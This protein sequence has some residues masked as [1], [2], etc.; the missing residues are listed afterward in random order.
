MFWL[1]AFAVSSVPTT[2]FSPLVTKM[3]PASSPAPVVVTL[4]LPAVGLPVPAPGVPK[5]TSTLTL[6][7]LSLSFA[8]WLTVM[9]PTFSLSPAVS[10][11]NVAVNTDVPHPLKQIQR[12]ESV[13]TAATTIGIL[14]V[15]TVPPFTVGLPIFSIELIVNDP[16]NIYVKAS[17]SS[18]YASTPPTNVRLALPVV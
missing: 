5:D 18:A 9:L 14:N 1:V 4:S 3:P 2:R 16:L 8:A 6:S 13:L 10:L 7:P 11:G 17:V 15:I 12:E